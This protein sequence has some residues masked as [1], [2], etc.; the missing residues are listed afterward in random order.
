MA[1]PWRDHSSA[2]AADA[3]S[4]AS[5]AVHVH[6]YSTQSAKAVDV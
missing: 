3:A 4:S 5:D 1:G 2:R 6:K